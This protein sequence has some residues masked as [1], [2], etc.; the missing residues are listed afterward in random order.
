MGQGARSTLKLTGK[1]FE[2][3]SDI[4]EGVPAYVLL[5]EKGRVLSRGQLIDDD[6]IVTSLISDHQGNLHVTHAHNI[7]TVSV[8]NPGVAYVNGTNALCIAKPSDEAHQIE[9]VSI[10]LS[11]N[12]AGSFYLVSDDLDIDPGSTTANTFDLAG[13]RGNGMV[14]TCDVIWATFLANQRRGVTGGEFHWDLPNGEELYLIA[15]D[16]LYSLVV[17]WIEEK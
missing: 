4:P 14:Q 17:N 13:M 6:G 11:T 8:T 3:P 7:Q 12:V 15:P 2:N 16:V 5:D 1:Y 10:Y 9:L